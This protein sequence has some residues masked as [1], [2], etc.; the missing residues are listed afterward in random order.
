MAKVKSVPKDCLN[1]SAY[2]DIL[3]HNPISADRTL[4]IQFRGKK[5][6][7]K[8]KAITTNIG[9]TRFFSIKESFIRAKLKRRYK[10]GRTG[11]KNL[12]AFKTSPPIIMM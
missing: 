10:K 3:A 2:L 5:K 4:I 11:K 7:K 9:I 6:V 12:W 1:L 8:E